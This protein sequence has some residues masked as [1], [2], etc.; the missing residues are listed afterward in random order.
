[1]HQIH[2]FLRSIAEQLK[3]G[4]LISAEIFDQVTVFFSDIVGFT[5]LSSTSTPVQIVNFLNDLYTTF[6]DIITM[7]DVY[8]VGVTSRLHCSYQLPL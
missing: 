1:M 4:K 2:F 3:M 5:K 7:H 6:D 8:K